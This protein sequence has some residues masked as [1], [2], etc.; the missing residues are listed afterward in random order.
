MVSTLKPL[1][2]TVVDL[3]T[4]LMFGRLDVMGVANGS[5]SLSLFHAYQFTPGEYIK[6]SYIG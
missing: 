1:P 5:G 3:R 6:Y 4:V 2:D